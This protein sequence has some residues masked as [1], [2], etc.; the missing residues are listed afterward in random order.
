MH[1]HVVPAISKHVGSGH[2]W[3]GSPLGTDSASGYLVACWFL[4]EVFQ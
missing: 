4:I 1:Y 3:P 2:E